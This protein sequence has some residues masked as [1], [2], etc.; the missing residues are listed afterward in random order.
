MVQCMDGVNAFKFCLSLKTLYHLFS[1]A[2]DTT[3]SWNYPYFV[4]HANL[5]I[6]TLVSLKGAICLFYVK[7]FVYRIIGVLESTSKISLRLFS[8]THVPALR[9][10]LA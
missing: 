8:F 5:T 2:V 1:N 7:F 4:A 9:S 6:L 3:N 10:F